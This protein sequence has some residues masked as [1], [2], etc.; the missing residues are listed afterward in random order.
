[1]SR[2]DRIGYA[3]AAFVAV[4]TAFCIAVGTLWKGG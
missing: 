1:M 2:P 3:L 4:W